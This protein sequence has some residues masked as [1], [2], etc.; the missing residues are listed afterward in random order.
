MKITGTGA[1]EQAALQ[2]YYDDPEIRWFE[3]GYGTEGGVVGGP[4][5]EAG[6]YVLFHCGRPECCRP[7]GPFQTEALAREWSRQNGMTA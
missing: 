1:P 4:L 3:A 5:T 6:F 7:E 2:A